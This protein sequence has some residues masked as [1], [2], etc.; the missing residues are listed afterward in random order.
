MHHI[1]GAEGRTRTCVFLMSGIVFG[2]A[3][4]HWDERN[5]GE[6]GVVGPLTP[7]VD[8]SRLWQLAAD[9]NKET[10]TETDKGK[11]IMLQAHRAFICG[12]LL[13]RWDEAGW[14]LEPGGRRVD[15]GGA[16]FNRYELW[17]GNLTVEGTTPAMVAPR[18]TV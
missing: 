12:A 1:S 13:A 15:F 17:T 4:H 9:M 2:Y 16:Y 3:T 7:G 14:K 6:V 10:A 18:P 5:L 8:W 11:W